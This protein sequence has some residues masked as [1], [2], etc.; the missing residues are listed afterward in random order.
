MQTD[1]AD[2]LNSK[3]KLQKWINKNQLIKKDNVVQN[4]KKKIHTMKINGRVM[5]IS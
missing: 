3:Q 4:K 2:A 1:A 5:G